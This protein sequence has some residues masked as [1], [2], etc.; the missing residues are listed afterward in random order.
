MVMPAG[1]VWDGRWTGMQAGPAWSCRLARH[2]TVAGRACRLAPHGH[3]SWR[4]MGRSLGGHAGWPRM[5]MPVGEAW[6]GRWTGMQAECGDS[7]AAERAQTASGSSF[8]ATAVS[9]TGIR[10]F[11]SSGSD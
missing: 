7:A 1:E 10:D 8:S 5:F 2:G 4:G 11:S 3:A 6:D 9:A